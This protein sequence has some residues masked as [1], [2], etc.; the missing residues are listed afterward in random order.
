MYAMHEEP[1]KGFFEELQSLDE[2]TKRKVLVVATA[3]IMVAVI[4]FWLAYF[5]NIVASISQPSIAQN[6]PTSSAAETVP[7]QAAEPGPS[8]FARIGDGFTYM[9]KGLGS[10]LQAPRQYIVQPPK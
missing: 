2:P 1:K 10:I 3:V 4:Y 8:M 5:N 9:I 6:T 7:A